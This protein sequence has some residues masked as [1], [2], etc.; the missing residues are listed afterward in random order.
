MLHHA[1]LHARRH[2]RLRHILLSLFLVISAAT[3][4]ADTAADTAPLRVMLL[5]GD[6]N[7]NWKLTTPELCAILAEGGRFRVDVV[8]D[9][10]A[11][12][13]SDF[14]SCDVIVSNYN[15][16]K[17][18]LPVDKV[19]GAAVREAFLAHVRGGRGFVVVHAGSSSLYDW[20]EYQKLSITSWTPGVTS[21]GKPH[22]ARVTFDGAGADHPVT[23][24]LPPF[25][26]H[27]EYWENLVVQP[28][29]TALANVRTNAKYN[30]RGGPAPILFARDYGKGRA[31]CLLLGH[32]VL[33]M[34]NPGFRTLFKRGV[35]WAATGTVT[36]P[37]DKNWPTTEAAATTAR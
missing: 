18:P 2:T 36:I 14:A 12:Q 13:A 22:A 26:T 37:A 11:L 6:N 16:F 9:V 4:A 34:R 1:R 33:A 15:T 32:D 23:R 10:A 17:N 19:W 27:D 3:A 24:G 25:W 21:H 5:S 30:S 35:E 31:L 20:P 7:H 28:G 8:D 29:A